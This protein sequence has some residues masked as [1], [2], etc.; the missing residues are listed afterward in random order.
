MATVSSRAQTAVEQRR[1]SKITGSNMN[2]PQAA[3]APYVSDSTVTPAPAVQSAVSWPAI[4]AGAAAAAAVS[5]ILV[6]LGSGLDLLAVSP[7]FPADASL[8]A[9]T[10]FTAIWFIVIQWVAAGV[11]GYLAGR[12][13]TRWIG[14]HTHEVFFRDTA[15]GLIT[16]AVGSI[17]VVSVFASVGHTFATRGAQLAAG[18]AAGPA[19][20]APPGPY[21]Y[22]LDLLFRGNG[23]ADVSPPS[24]GADARAE[25][26]RILASGLANGEV[27]AADRSYLATLVSARTGVAP[28][29]AE[30]RI[31][32]F[33][34][35]AKEAADK[36]RKAAAAFALFTAISMLI[37][38]F[39]ACVAAA[40]GGQR[41]DLHY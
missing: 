30:Q 41:R 5:V 16:W 11:G 27:P 38:A 15:H 7:W 9:F 3:A 4:F 19:Q 17:I 13:R 36:A 23:A 8:T 39:I 2:I 26:M 6:A 35:Q 29:E 20:R 1:L 18:M 33:V 28:A 40:L 25:A 10:V 37:G 21:G 14:T 32:A 22:N 12:L 24:A 34:A 31:D